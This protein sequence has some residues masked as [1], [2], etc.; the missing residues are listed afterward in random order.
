MRNRTIIWLLLGAGVFSLLLV[1]MLVA[2]IT[3]GNAGGNGGFGFDDRIQV[4]EI[5]GEL[6]ES[7]SIIFQ[8][9]QYENSSSV[10]AILLNINSPGGDVA[11][12]QELYTEIKRLR[13]EKG[14]VVVAYISSVG[15]S[16]AYYL[17]C[18]ADYIIA[19]PGTLVGS[20]SSPLP[21]LR[22]RRS[23]TLQS[24]Y[25]VCLHLQHPSSTSV[26]K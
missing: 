20:I 1:T 2:V 4:V 5:E 9:K 16:G 17:A 26:P 7:R 23:R 8:L 3:F 15:A 19:S 25:L 22:G 12:S 10:P 11:A 24:R 6:V 13:E 14:K 21:G 18:A